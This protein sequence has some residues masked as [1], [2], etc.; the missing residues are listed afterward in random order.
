MIALTLIR[1]VCFITS[2]ARLVQKHNTLDETL[3]PLN[4]IKEA[5]TSLLL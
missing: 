5:P 2:I 1:N 3:E 4:W